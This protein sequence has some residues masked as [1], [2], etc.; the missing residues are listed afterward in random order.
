MI[1][2]VPNSPRCMVPG[3]RGGLGYKIDG[4][5]IVPLLPGQTKGDD[6]TLTILGSGNTVRPFWTNT[7]SLFTRNL[8][9]NG[10]LQDIHA[11]GAG[12]AGASPGATWQVIG[13]LGDDWTTPGCTDG[14]KLFYGQPQLGYTPMGISFSCDVYAETNDR[15]SSAS[16]FVN[17]SPINCFFTA[18]SLIYDTICFLPPIFDRCMDAWVVPATV[19]KM[20]WEPYFVKAPG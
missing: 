8:L 20:T 11:I 17:G 13:P 4:S 15:Q 3:T 2:A 12:S 19:T 1:P 14:Y 10:K 16:F 7:P 5:G 9:T 18:D 6:H